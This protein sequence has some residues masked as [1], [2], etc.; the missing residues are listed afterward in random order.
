MTEKIATRIMK[1][2][3]GDG[4]AP[5][6]LSRYP[7]GTSDGGQTKWPDKFCVKDRFF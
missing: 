7:I 6:W 3:A 2:Q 4:V 5:E 1:D